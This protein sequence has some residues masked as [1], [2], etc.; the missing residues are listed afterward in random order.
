MCFARGWSWDGWRERRQEFCAEVMATL[1]PFHR[2][3][4]D[5]W[6][7]VAVIGAT[8]EATVF[9]LIE[10]RKLAA[11]NIS[12]GEGRRCVRVLTDSLADYVAGRKAS[13]SFEQWMA[14]LF[15]GHSDV[16]R[17]NI[18][19]AFNTTNELVTRLQRRG[20]LTEAGPVRC[21][22]NET[23]RIT[24]QSLARFVKGRLL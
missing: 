4:I 21:P 2:P 1:L 24:R 14:A 18:A 11:L 12:H 23:P 6:G 20:L 19:R 5:V 22:V 3:T 16:L 17:T 13:R 7:A 9:E 8:K 10:D 15:P